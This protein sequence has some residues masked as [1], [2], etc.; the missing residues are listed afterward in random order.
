MDKMSLDQ[1]SHNM[2]DI[3]SRACESSQNAN[4][5]YA[6]ELLCDLVTNTPGLMPARE[7]L[8]EYE[9]KKSRNAGFGAKIKAYFVGLSFPSKYRKM[10]DDEPLDVMKACEEVLTEYLFNIP[11]LEVLA[12]AAVAADGDFIAVETR[13][14]IHDLQPENEENL[15]K[16]HALRQGETEEPEPEAEDAE[17][18]DENDI[19]ELMGKKLDS[20]E[21]LFDVIGQL[22]E[23]L[24]KDKESFE[25]RRQLG[26]Y[27]AQA[28]DYA[29]AIEYF[30]SVV[31][32]DDEFDPAIDKYLEKAMI[33]RYDEQIA[34]AT[35]EE[36]AK[37]AR[38]KFEYR[39]ARAIN[40]VDLYP[41]DNQLHYDL[42][43]L[44]FQDKQ[45]DEAIE[46]LELGRR[47]P[48]RHDSSN[49]YL[50]RCLMAK[51]EYELAIE[52]LR[53]AVREMGRMDEDKMEAMYYLAN[54][55]EKLDMD[56]EA[57]EIYKEIYKVEI[58][59]MDV[60][61]RIDDFYMKEKEQ[62]S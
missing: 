15:Q 30:E 7:L 50:G 32:E 3:F 21:E 26:D 34:A 47:N 37:L 38:E 22:E 8:R 11:V 55:Y 13:T 20:K 40:R 31:G 4:L 42:G 59:F 24:K 36:A 10:I 44:Y 19:S 35:P 17:D 53:D 60:A 2:R 56:E 49:V 39:L 18:E 61:S 5:D 62:G 46:E 25:I 14:L 41:D 16:L 12:D 45:Y 52:P 6:I 51:G 28:G 48:K 1:V 9:A 23:E 27:Y 29:K 57:L 43:V 33:A 58:S 54:A